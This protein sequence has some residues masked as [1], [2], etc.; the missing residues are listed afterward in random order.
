MKVASKRGSRVSANCAGENTSALGTEEFCHTSPSIQMN[1]LTNTRFAA[2]PC[3][4]VPLLYDPMWWVIP[5]P[6]SYLRYMITSG[7]LDKSCE[8]KRL[9]K[10]LSKEK[11]PLMAYSAAST[12]NSR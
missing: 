2:A 10:S 12:A 8:A 11:G 6:A 4:S 1:D 7:L 5:N 9:L 3:P